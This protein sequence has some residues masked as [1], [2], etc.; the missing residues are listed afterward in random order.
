[1]R[2]KTCHYS[3]S[4]LTEHR[5]PE[6]GAAFDPKNPGT[7]LTEREIWNRR[8][9]WWFAGVLWMSGIIILLLTTF[10]KSELIGPFV[11]FSLVIQFA[12]LL[13]PRRGARAIR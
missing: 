11:A 2:C 13:W 8:K 10:D 6:C 9:A 3:L 12:V 4:G 1:M 5:C 7:F